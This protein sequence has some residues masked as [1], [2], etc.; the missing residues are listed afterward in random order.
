MTGAEGGDSITVGTDAGHPIEM[1]YVDTAGDSAEYTILLLHGLFDHKAT[2]QYVMPHFDARFR[3]IAPDLVGSGY[4]SKPRFDGEPVDERYSVSMVAA[5]VRRFIAALSL[6]N[7]IL[8]GSSLGGGIALKLLLEEWT[9]GPTIRGLV[10]I[11]AAGYPQLLPGYIQLAGSWPAGLLANRLLRRAARELGILSAIVR[12]TFRQ[13]FFDPKKIPAE[14][15][16]AALEV[17]CLN[18]TASAYRWAARNVVPPDLG[19]FRGRYREITCPTLII[20]GREDRIIPPLSALLFETD[21]QG[22]K[23]HVFDEC[24]HA[25]HLEYPEE[26]AIAIRDWARYSL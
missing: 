5:F 20:W 9:R 4:S 26:T 24:G 16:A 6:D 22:S 25:P 14:L 2:W 19:T 8:V 10:L 17:L 11:G 15:E 23:L 18:G 13:V 7:L 1:A 21:I 3:S 12:S